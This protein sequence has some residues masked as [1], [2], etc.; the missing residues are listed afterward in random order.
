MTDPLDRYL[1]PRGAKPA[2]DPLDELLA[3]RRRHQASANIIRG[4][5]D[6][7]TA[8][9]AN[10]LARQFG[11]PAETAER[12]LPELESERQRRA[13]AELIDRHP[14]VGAWAADPRNAAVGRDDM[15]NLARVSAA[16]ERRFGVLKA[17]EARSPTLRNFFSGVWE[18]FVQGGEQA[19]AAG[20]QMMKDLGLRAP[21]GARGAPQ[22][23]NI[24]TGRDLRLIQRAQG[25]A[26]SAAPAFRSSTMRGIYGGVSSLAQTAPALAVS[27]ALRNPAPVLAVTGGSTAL[28]GYGKY[29]ARGAAP[30]L[31]AVGGVA[32]G[33]I[34]TA[35]ELLPMGFAVKA[36]GKA[37]FGSFV[38]GLLAKDVPGEQVSTFLSDAVD[39]ALA[40]PEKSW[41]EFLEERPEAAYETL[42][43]TVV[44]GL[45]LGGPALL[46]RQYSRSRTADDAETDAGFLIDL[47]DGAAGSKVRQRDP[48]AFKRFLELHGD[49]AENVYIP[50]EKL[51]E[52]FQSDAYDVGDFFDGYADEIEDAAA[53]GGDVVIPLSEAATG[54]AGSKVW[55]ALKDDV[56]LSPGGQS[57]REARSFDDAMS[58]ELSAMGEQLARQQESE[59]AAQAPRGKVYETVRDELMRASYTPD[60]ASS[61]AQLYAA[62]YATLAEAFNTDAWSEFQ[63]AGLRVQ[64]TLPARLGA[65]KAA[66][67]LD[68]AIAAMKRA[69]TSGQPGLKF[70]RSLLEFI[71]DR[72]GVEDVEGDLAAIGADA[73][74]KEKPFRK[75]LVRPKRDKSPALIADDSGNDNTPDAVM[76]AAW[77]AGYFSEFGENRPS[78]DDLYQAMRDELRGRA[79]Y[80]DD[81][82]SGVDDMRAAALEL[83]EILDRR[84]LDPASASKEEIREAVE[85]YQTAAAEGR[86]YG[87]DKDGKRGRITFT[88]TG[89]VIELFEAR[90]LSTFLHESGHLFLEEM[91]RNADRPDA[92]QWMRD[93]KATIEK[94]FAT[95]GHP[96][97]DGHI[98][99]AAHELFARGFERFLMEGKAPSPALRKAFESFKSWLLQIYKSVAR[100]NVPLTP[101]VSD[102]LERLLATETE[103]QE[104]RQAQKIEALFTSAAEAGMTEA[105]FAAYRLSAAEA[106]TDAFDALLAKTMRVIRAEHTKDWK[107]EEEGVRAKVAKE[108]DGR[109]EFQVLAVLTAK[110]PRVKLSKAWLLEN[111]GDAAL[112]L[113]PQAVPPIYS[114]KAPVDADA[115]A[116]LNGFSSGDEM[117]RTLMGV[118][119]RR[120]ELRELGDKRSVREVFIAEGAREIMR[121]RHGDP[122][123]DGSIEAEALALIHNERQGEV[124]AAE[125]RALAKRTGQKPT[126]YRIAREWAARKIADSR[127]V[128]STSGAAIQQY[129]RA[130]ARAGKAAETA[131]LAGDRRETLRQKQAQM[132]NSALVMEAKK[133]RDLVDSAV[134][135][136]GK[137]ARSATMGSV[138]QAYLAQAHALLERY[139]FRPRSQA[140]INEKESFDAWLKARE[141]EGLELNVPPRLASD[142]KHFSR[143]TVTELKGLTDTVSQIVHL[144]KH[145]N[146]LLKDK[147]KRELQAIAE[148]IEAAVLTNGPRTPA[149]LR[150]R[151]TKAAKVKLAGKRFLAMHRK[152][153]S[154]ARQMDGGRDGGPVWEHFI[155]TMNESA[156]LEAV[157]RA[158]ATRKLHEISKPVLKAGKLGGKGTYFPHL[159]ISLNR[160]ERIGIVA[161]MGNAGNLQRLLDGEG[162]DMSD[163]QPIV[164]SL[165]KVDMDFVQAIWDFFESYRPQIGAKEKRVYGVEPEW[166][167]PQPLETPHGTYRGGYY[168]IKYDPRRSSK[169]EQ[170]NDAEEAK[171]QMKGAYTSATPRRSFAKSRVE[172]VKGRPL[173]YNLTGLWQGVTEICHDLAWHEWLIDTNKLL[174]HRTVD[175]AIR[176]T[177]GPEAIGVFKSAVQDIAAGDVPAQNV[178][179]TA[180]NHVRMGATVAGLGLNLKTA[181][182]QPF[183]ISQSMVRVGPQWIALGL[184]QWFKSPI[185]V[186]GQISAKSDFMRL[187]SKTMQREINEIQNRISGGKSKLMELVE[188]SFF[189]MIQKTQMTVDVPT[190]LGAYEKADATGNDEARSI[191]LADQA[192][193]DAQGGGQVS[194]LSAIQRGGPLQKLFVNFYS[195]FNVTWNLSAESVARTD[196]RKPG[197]VL[198]L[199]T[200][201]LMLYSVPATMGFLLN[202][203]WKAAQG[204]E[205]NE[206][207]SALIAENLGFMM[208]TMVGV[209][210]LASGVQSIAGVRQYENAYGGPAGLRA[211]QEFDKAGKQIG[212]GEIDQALRK[213][214]I[215]TA[216]ILFHLPS[217]QINRTWDGAE[218]LVDGEENPAVLVTGAR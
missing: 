55:D 42:V 54:L 58:A 158:D 181:L 103:I 196:F 133:A 215:G 36:F 134:K 191:A 169:A 76:L 34:E 82:T 1:A 119:Q 96:I 106:R 202:E 124:M 81:R 43:G 99:E 203:A 198:R 46:A 180:I 165:T 212:Q 27:V 123:A 62:H 125:I 184:V 18:N 97:K 105:E 194:D 67:Q 153:A 155:R 13:A 41:K 101:E 17:P 141:D 24:D 108:I 211:L 84:G 186:V 107:A 201:F 19:K 218:A 177:Y 89:A 150:T 31:A 151:N 90:N 199:A 161:N 146:R 149:D 57:L 156:D 59:R 160:E 40:N 172:E 91:I 121:E 217:G 176:S 210:E 157:M 137:I 166:V 104:A 14:K 51:R 22:I 45:A 139:D 69:A 70:G 73:W 138:D 148:S 78:V 188:A 163:L 39:T 33:G 115:I 126:P 205:D 167:E 86:S 207:V 8:G 112:Q 168:P 193:R 52:L 114:D 53:I 142:Q 6:P 183:G 92:P 23:N 206:W 135:R 192:V 152:M 15:D 171:R 209:R 182:L 170:H 9:R 2:S 79:R 98:P 117:V 72:G 20:R 147:A 38:S 145:K 16:F 214:L 130:A 35:T 65:V 28:K 74:H 12:Q 127:V 128:D 25:R 44:Q 154:L 50:G 111:Y 173:L 61:Q 120:K 143:M 77:E 195:F 88:E 129:Q 80:A 87:Q 21:R 190:W 5:A 94:W 102:V 213:S 118:E 159:G 174:R 49:E 11:L 116:E 144:G 110:E 93:D 175:S 26:A 189:I 162:W 178:F 85:Y 47:A 109:R 83:Y 185:D 208:G 200:D 3:T 48:E 179:E 131:M 140:S 32:E 56:R 68:I 63:R 136:L 64:Q 71:A 37:G 100:L 60:T 7:D 164:D 66:D 197:E 75:K 113:V 29:R 132:L 10:V 216:G 4:G 204:D 187:R 30:G 95:N 122:L